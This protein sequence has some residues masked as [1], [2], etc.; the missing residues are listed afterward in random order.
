MAQNNQDERS[1]PDQ[2]GRIVSEIF[3]FVMANP[4]A[5]DASLAEAGAQMTLARLNKICD[6]CGAL[7]ACDVP[8]VELIPINDAPIAR[9]SG[10]EQRKMH[11]LRLISCKLSHAF[12][13][14]LNPEPIDRQVSIGIDVYLRRLFGMAVY[15]RLN[16]QA[17]RI[18]LLSGRS[19]D[20]VLRGV[21]S[22]FMH[23]QFFMNV[24][25]RLGLSFRNF[26]VAHHLF[27]GDLNES[28][29][30]GSAPLGK[31]AFHLMMGALLNDV[32]L[33]AKSQDDGALL[34][35]LYG[36]RTA[37]GLEE[38]VTLMSKDRRESIAQG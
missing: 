30:L 29:P 14:K 27:M 6:A 37:R 17:E 12:D 11:L 22:N 3:S 25:V 33:I 5:F 28:R 2:V 13:K 35:F 20:A 26:D 9:P 10:N 16:E 24:L 18:L 38:V 21:M 31:K 32:F 1:G 7:P 4:D 8:Q 15:R 19:D 23:R 36:Q 34:D